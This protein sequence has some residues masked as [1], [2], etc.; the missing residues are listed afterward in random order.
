MKYYSAMRR[1]E[2]LL[3]HECGVRKAVTEAAW[4]V[5]PFCEL[6]RAGALK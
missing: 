6:C 4:G 3:V 2:A 1:R 5:T